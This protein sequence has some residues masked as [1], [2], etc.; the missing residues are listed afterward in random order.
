MYAVDI[1]LSCQ[2]QSLPSFQSP[3]LCSILLIIHD[4]M[5][6]MYELN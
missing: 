5:Q 2:V 3:H 1:E 6:L 4:I